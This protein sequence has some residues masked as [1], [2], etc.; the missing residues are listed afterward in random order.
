MRHLELT[1]NLQVVHSL[2]SDTFADVP[3]HT[4]ITR[5]HVSSDRSSS[6]HG[7]GQTNSA[8]CKIPRFPDHPSSV[9]ERL[10]HIARKGPV[11]AVIF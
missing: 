4:C 3:L 9:T 1:V 6:S 2:A 10:A 11:V 7:V 5:R 8:L